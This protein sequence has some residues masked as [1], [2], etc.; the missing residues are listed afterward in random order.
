MAASQLILL[1]RL[2]AALA[3]GPT[4]GAT[5]SGVVVDARTLDPVGGASVRL[6]NAGL[7]AQ[8][9]STGSFAFG[10]HELG[11]DS[12]VVS[13]GDYVTGG[14]LLGDIEA[15][16]IRLEVRLVRRRSEVADTSE[17]EALLRDAV[18]F[19]EQFGGHLWPREEF[20]V[21]APRAQYPLELLPF[22]GFVEALEERGGGACVTL[23]RGEGCAEI[24]VNGEPGSTDQLR[25]R[26]PA[27]VAAIVIVP[28]SQTRTVPNRG[29]QSGV[30]GVFLSERRP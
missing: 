9:D 3:T 15:G 25:I 28:P 21:H 13:H 4:L 11:L 17:A 14:L 8:T 6:R 5:V 1:I 12:L 19:S 10:P 2:L 18:N 7:E 27:E 30:I 20:L 16:S 24:W 23:P 29:G 26:F 22:S